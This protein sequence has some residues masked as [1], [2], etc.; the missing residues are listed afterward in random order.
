[1]TDVICDQRDCIYWR[2]G[3]CTQSSIELFGGMCMDYTHDD[4]TN[5]KEYQTEYSIAMLEGKH[6]EIRHGKRIVINGEEFF[7]EDDDRND[8]SFVRLTHGR[9]G[10]Y[11]GSIEFVKSHWERTLESA[12]QLP[13]VTT[14]PLKEGT[15]EDEQG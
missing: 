6:R 7:T 1:M 9:T 15:N 11:A 4:Y 8:D 14:L 2:N 10:A 3:E 13:D 12:A 5:G